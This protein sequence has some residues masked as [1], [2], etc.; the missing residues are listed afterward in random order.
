[1]KLYSWQTKLW[2]QFLKL[3]QTGRLPHA[4]VLTGVH[5]LGKNEFIQHLVETVL[6]LS[7]VETGA[8]CGHCH[9]CQVFQ[10]GNH[11]DHTEI[12]PE[13]KGKQIKIEQIRS[14]KEKQ[15]LTPTVSTW[16]TVVISP[17]YAMNVNA[18]NSLL[19]L[20]EE[21]ADN[22]LIIL[23]TSK[24]NVMPITI[25]SRC[26]LLHMQVPSHEQAMTWFKNNA[27]HALM[28]LTTDLLNMAKG[29][30]IAVL[31]MLEQ[32]IEQ[33]YHQVNN[34]FEAVLSKTVN[35]V[36]IANTWQQFDL[37]KVMLQLQLKIQQLIVS[38]NTD[39]ALFRKSGVEYKVCWKISDCI[40]YTT[41]LIS[42][43]NNNN[44]T[45]LIEEFLV[46]VM[47]L[48]EQGKQETI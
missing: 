8:A 17:A 43:Q 14:L 16:K 23:V 42:S 45:L 7:P 30:P 39:T 35:P 37:I 21:P 10:A 2:E 15:Q 25:K 24:L 32:G 20:L 28:P 40:V 13:E 46:N 36:Q 12:K 22:T 27:P 19:K 41:K 5:G 26:Q 48:V 44:K 38:A 1:M 33:Q 6:C 18:N 3:K 34:D 31:E 4:I 29:G 9:S 47:Q 11:P